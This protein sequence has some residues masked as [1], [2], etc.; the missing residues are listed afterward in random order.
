MWIQ[1]PAPRNRHL[2]PFLFV[3]AMLLGG[4]SA[5]AQCS[6]KLNS[7]P[8]PAEFYGF[9]LGMTKEEVKVLVPQTAFKGA[10]DFGVAKTTINPSFDP[11]ID[12]EKFAGVRSI[13]LDFLDEHLTSLWIGYDE[14]Y[15]IHSVEDFVKQI[16][17]SL[18]LT[19]TWTSWKIK[20]QQLRCDD[21]QI[22]VSAVAGAP[23][24]RIIDISAE[25]TVAARRLAKEEEKEAAEAGADAEP[26]AEG[27]VADK[28]SK[29]YY[30]PGCKPTKEI[31]EKD[32]VVF[33][34]IEEAEKSGFKLG[35]S[36]Q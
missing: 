24:V 4:V 31:I 35:R 25:D 10:D 12:K 26:E 11:R 28:T 3:L 6:Q 32:R 36:C 33:K 5:R 20:G 13:S 29:T 16:S 2:F 14:T 21:F 9:R 18:H 7:L 30:L 27:I 1:I 17:Q 22:F 19:G 15:K 23:S 8:A 34:T